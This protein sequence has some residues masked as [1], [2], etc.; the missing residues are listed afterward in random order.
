MFGRPASVCVCVCVVW[1]RT[2]REINRSQSWLLTKLL[3]YMYV[4]VYV[5]MHVCTSCTCVLCVCM[6][7]CYV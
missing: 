2:S 1:G 6:F 4:S 7:V 5:C 3:V